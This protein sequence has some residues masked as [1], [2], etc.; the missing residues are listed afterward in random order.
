MMSCP[1]LSGSPISEPIAAS[2]LE[3]E[4]VVQPS[5]PMLVPLAAI[6]LPVK[7]PRRSFTSEKLEQLTTS[8]KTLGILEPLLVR[9]KPSG[10]YELVAGER[11]YRAAHIAGLTCVPVV[12]RELTDEE[13]LQLSLVEN[14]QR[15]D[16]NPIDET[17]GILQLLSLKLKLSV[18]EV[19]A[20]LYRIEHEV[21]GVTAP[22]VMGSDSFKEICA[23]FNELGKFTW[24]S[25]VTNRL[26]LLKLPEDILSVVRAG[27]LEYTKA[28]ALARVKDELKRQSLLEEAIR[29]NISLSELRKRIKPS[30]PAPET[31][32][33]KTLMERAYRRIRESKVWENPEK[34]ERVKVLLSELSALIDG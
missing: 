12:V 1:S 17:E 11:R 16:L 25:F 5:N 21:K 23:T 18:Q 7:R 10:E 30:S 34:W 13:A 33:S 14:L 24:K 8:V 15:E 19:V 3:N 6:T 20:L 9:Q 32:Y 27:S 28:Q 4:R 31:D 26:P 2:V 29:D 22:N